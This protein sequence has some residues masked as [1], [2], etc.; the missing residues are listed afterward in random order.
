M[1]TRAYINNTNMPHGK[2]NCNSN[3]QYNLCM[4]YCQMYNMQNRNH[5]NGPELICDMSMRK[6]NSMLTLSSLRQ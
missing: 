2:Q 5:E 1:I 4:E 6:F 3:T